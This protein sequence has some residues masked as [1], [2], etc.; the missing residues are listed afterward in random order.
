[1]TTLA[2]ELGLLAG[3]IIYGLYL[4]GTPARP[5]MVASTLVA[6]CLNMLHA[7]VIFLLPLSLESKV[8]FVYF[9]EFGTAIADIFL[10]M[11]LTIMASQLCTEGV[12]GTSYALV[13]SIQ[14]LGGFL[15]NFLASQI[16]NVLGI[17]EGKMDRL[18]YMSFLC[19]FW[20]LSPLPLL[21]MLP[22][23]ANLTRPN[24]AE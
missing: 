4:R 21:R 17:S 5:L 10:F 6:A 22:E 3:V 13:L 2:E 15:D 7:V 11:P 1:M 8:L 9:F 14:N 24:K 19:A 16:M 18:W 20:F 12:E 23:N